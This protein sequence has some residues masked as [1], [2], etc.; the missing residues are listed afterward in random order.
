[1][2]K[3][4]IASLQIPV[5]LHVLK[6]IINQLDFLNIITYVAEDFNFVVF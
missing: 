3:D 5:F 4:N 1:V 2:R 6:S